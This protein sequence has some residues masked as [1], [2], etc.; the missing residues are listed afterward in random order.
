MAELQQRR[1]TRTELPRIT[2]QAPCHDEKPNKTGL[3]CI[4][5][6]SAAPGNCV[7]A[8]ADF[9]AHRRALRPH[10]PRPSRM[11]RGPIPLPRSASGSAHVSA[12]CVTSP[13]HRPV[14]PGGGFRQARRRGPRRGRGRRRLDPSRRDGRTFRSQHFL[15]PRRHQGD[16]PAHQEDLRRASD[17]LA[18]RS[19]S[20]SLRQG[21][22]RSDHRP[23]RG[24]PASASLAAGDPRARQEGRRRRSIRARR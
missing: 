14:D 17:D 5:T 4:P 15:R 7:P 22:L 19:L 2:Q 16:A 9:S 24:R 8:A 18:L 13:R 3:S 23:C 10:C 12:I 6:G 20:R 1:V 11:L 21:R